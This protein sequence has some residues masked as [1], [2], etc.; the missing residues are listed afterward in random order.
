MSEILSLLRF[1]NDYKLPVILQTEQSKCGLACLA[2]VSTYFGHRLDLAT[3][4]QEAPIS[5]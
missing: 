3:A 4:R 1:S 5:L 2:M